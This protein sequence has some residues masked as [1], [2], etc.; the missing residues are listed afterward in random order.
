VRKTILIILCPV[1]VLCFSGCVV[2]SFTEA[3][4]VFGKG[5]PEKYDL[6]AGE[7]SKIKV[8]GRCDIQYYA[9]PS[10][11]VTLEVQPN[12]REY[13]VTEVINNEL[14]IRT[15][16][17]IN[18]RSKKTLSP[19]LTVYAPALNS[20]KIA[21][22]CTFKA[23]DKI[24]A[25]S[26]YLEISGAGDGKIELDVNSLKASMSGAGRFEISG[27]ADNA[28]IAMSGAGEL[29]AFSLQTRDASVNLSGVG[30]IKINSS[31]KLYVKA[32]GAGKV[33]YKGSPAL[34]LNTSGAVNIK[35]AD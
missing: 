35:K 7:Y 2:T 9:A 3:G 21:G 20:L 19:V 15:T 32:S 8:D 34:S 1:I 23:N 18:F 27:K 4:T 29:N 13:F 22:M 17:K 30:T 26:F 16:R 24:T 10:D 33:E 28:E 12:L 5:D 14:I 25:D 11:T 6:K 31:E